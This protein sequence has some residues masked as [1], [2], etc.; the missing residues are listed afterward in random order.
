MADLGAE[1]VG[2]LQVIPRQPAA[3]QAQPFIVRAMCCI[4]HRQMCGAIAIFLYVRPATSCNATGTAVMPAVFAN[5]VA[6]GAE[7]A[8]WLRTYAAIRVGPSRRAAAAG[9]CKRAP[10][11]L[12]VDA[13]NPA[14]LR[15]VSAHRCGARG[16]AA[17]GVGFGGERD[18]AEVGVAVG[19]VRLVQHQVRAV[20]QP[21]QRH[22]A[23]RAGG[24]WLSALAGSG[25]MTL[26]WSGAPGALQVPAVLERP[27]ASPIPAARVIL[28]YL[29][30]V[31]RV[32][33]SSNAS[34]APVL[35][36]EQKVP[37]TC[38]PSPNNPI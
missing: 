28:G 34:V 5:P 22:P 10:R 35:L 3:A 25:L 30:C 12:E 14:W 6:L 31:Y 17:A 11:R 13:R 4:I 23:L 2:R 20:L 18:G 24:P 32:A 1:S 36:V 33:P 19:R 8:D 15:T 38:S 27:T 9:L 16:E 37:A 26:C 29:V 7:A 21:R